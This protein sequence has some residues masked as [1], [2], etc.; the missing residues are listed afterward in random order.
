MV[1]INRCL[2]G[3]RRISGYSWY[4]LRGSNSILGSFEYT[5]RL[6]IVKVYPH[7]EYLFKRMVPINRCLIGERRISGYSWY[8]LRGSNSILGSFEYTSRLKIVKVYPHKEISN[9]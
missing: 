3:V 1:P 2:I 5:S 7:K 4:Q 9:I 8:Q 6:K